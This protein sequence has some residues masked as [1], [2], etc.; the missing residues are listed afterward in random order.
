VAL[1]SVIVIG[2]NDATHLP[3]A[4]RSVMRQTL[5][6]IE[7]I[8][9]DDASTDETP[10][11]TAAL[12]AADPR[13]TVLR[14]EANSGGC[15]APRND[16]MAVATGRYLMFCDSDDV[17]TRR[18]CE[19]LSGAAERADADLACGEFVRRHHDPTRYI[20]AYRD[21][22]RSATVLDGILDRPAQL[23]DTPPWNK[24]YRRSFVEEAGLT[25]PA[26]LLYEDLL[27]VT[28]AYCRAGRI[29]IVP[30]LVYVWNVRRSAGALS[31]TNRRDLRRWHDRIEV[32]RRIDAYLDDS[33]APAALR[34]AKDARFLAL[35]L[36]V[37]LRELR[38]AAPADRGE[39]METARDYCAGIAIPD[40]S[41]GNDDIPLGCRIGA[42]MIG[43][44]DVE[45]ALAAADLAVTESASS[46]LVATDARLRWTA[47]YADNPRADA[48]LDVTDQGWQQLGWAKRPYL[49]VVSRATVDGTLLRLEGQVHDLLDGLAGVE[50]RGTVRVTTRVGDPVWSGPV[51]VDAAEGGVRFAGDVELAGVGRRLLRPT[52]GYEL[53]LDLELR[54]GQETARRPLTARDVVLPDKPIALP[55]PFRWLVGDRATLVESNGRLVLRLDPPPTYKRAIG[56]ASWLRY[57]AG[58]GRSV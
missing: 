55:T 42:F 39:L 37:F 53:R 4:V 9:V 28:E 20:P 36:M 1:V 30:D 3:T 29:A 57:T 27:F 34:A 33:G 46:D 58:H 6:D 41:A 13:I 11:V 5:R 24:L 15:S 7:I 22:Y 10:A 12:A 50:P 43:Q 23:H 45:R 44:G 47:A 48:V 40:R 25:F 56:A 51:T 19:K 49:A 2:Y 17:L 32:N 26:G 35:D 16:G 21:F 18:A 31:I 38:E 14:R 8:V 52:A 54:R